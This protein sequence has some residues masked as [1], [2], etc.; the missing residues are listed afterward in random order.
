MTEDVNDHGE[1]DVK[2]I[3]IIKDDLICITPYQF[4]RQPIFTVNV[5]LNSLSDTLPLNP[6]YEIVDP[7][8]DFFC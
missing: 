7:P 4:S 1:T 6:C 5:M 2:K 3:N 8:P